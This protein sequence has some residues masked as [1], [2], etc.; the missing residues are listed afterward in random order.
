MRIAHMGHSIKNVFPADATLLGRHL[1]DVFRL[2]RPDI[3]LEWNRVCSHIYF[4][5]RK[6][7]IKTFL[8]YFLMVD[9]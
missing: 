4:K 9:I 5:H 7:I 1:E 2:I 6:I 3:L 8:R